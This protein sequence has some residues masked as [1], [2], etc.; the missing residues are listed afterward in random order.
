MY[1]FRHRYFNRLSPSPLAA[2]LPQFR[3][4]TCDPDNKCGR[5]LPY[6]ASIWKV[7]A[8]STAACNSLIFHGGPAQNHRE[9][10]IGGNHVTGF[11]HFVVFRRADASL[12]STTS[13]AAHHRPRNDPVTRRAIGPVDD[14]D[15]TG[16]SDGPFRARAARAAI[17]ACGLAGFGPTMGAGFGA[18]ELAVS[19]AVAPQSTEPFAL[20]TQPISSG[21]PLA[22]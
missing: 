16:A 4:R 5:I 6:W 7:C 1:S 17:F 19:S 3:N 9:H 20:A 13:T 2:I 18:P 21:G 8:G 12:K 15:R 14:H 11:T 22:K 10:K